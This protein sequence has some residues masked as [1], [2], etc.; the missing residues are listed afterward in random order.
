MFHT[1]TKGARKLGG[2]QDV[3]PRPCDWPDCDEK[4]G[5]VFRAPKSSNDLK[6]YHWFCLDHVREYNKSWNYYGHMNETQVESDRRRDT[7]WQRPT[8]PLGVNRAAGGF[9]KRQFNDAFGVFDDDESPGSEHQN[10]GFH[11]TTPEGKAAQIL[12]LQPP[13]TVETV[14]AKYKELVKR[15]HPDA[16]DGDK[17]SEEKFKQISQAYQTIMTILSP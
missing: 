1:N 15:H 2:E 4:E 17:A 14:K 5:G 12:D 9:D 8:W 6:N 11:A 16:N 7:V 3:D 13:F 10:P